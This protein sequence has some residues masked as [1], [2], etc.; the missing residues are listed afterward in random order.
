MRSAGKV[1]ARYALILGEDELAKQALMVRDMDARRDYPD[2]IGLDCSL[3]DLR[4]A[5]ANLAD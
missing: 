1:G 3:S 4:Q 2:A 5:L